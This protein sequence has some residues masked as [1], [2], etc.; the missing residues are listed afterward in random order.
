MFMIHENIKVGLVTDHVPIQEVNKHITPALLE[1]KS[2]QST[3][4][5]VKI[6]ESINLKLRFLDLIRIVE[7]MVLLAKKTVKL[8]SLH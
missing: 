5:Y 8:S 3:K 1:Q 7:T 4:L 6:L 2:T